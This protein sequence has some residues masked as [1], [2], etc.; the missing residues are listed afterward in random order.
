MKHIEISPWVYVMTAA[1]LLLLPFRVL[2]SGVF[3]A[4]FHELCHLYVLHAFRIPVAGISVGIG[5]AKIRVTEMEGIHGFLSA[6]AGPA[7]SI[8]LCILHRWFPAVA[9]FGLVQGLFN[10]I[11]VYP[12]DGGRMLRFLLEMTVP[13]YAQRIELTVSFLSAGFILGLAARYFFEGFTVLLTI[14]LGFCFGKEKLLAKRGGNGYNSA[15]QT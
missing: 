12:L 2:V 15:D 9:L 1:G 6:A 8:L 13:R 3:A 5:G 11:P 4:S 7:G 10:L 14:L